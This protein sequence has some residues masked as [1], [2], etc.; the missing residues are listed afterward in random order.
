MATTPSNLIATVESYLSPTLAIQPSTSNDPSAPAFHL[1]PL[2]TQAK[3]RNF[4]P[5]RVKDMRALGHS[6]QI[7]SHIP[8]PASALTCAKLNDALYAANRL[9]A[10]KFVPLALLP[11][12]AGEGK[13]AAREL[14]KCITKYRFVGGVLGLG[15]GSS[16]SGNLDDRS[17][18]ELWALAEKYRVPVALRE[19]WP[20][21]SELSK[22]YQHNLP[23]SVL[24]PLVSHIHAVLN[25]QTALYLLHLYLSSTFD[26][27]P[28]LRLIL[29]HPGVLPS[30]FRRITAFLALIPDADK[31]K[32]PFLDV[33]QHN[34]YLTTADVQDMSSL[35]SLLE[36]I[37]V[38]RVLYASNYPFEERGKELMEELRGSGFLT[39]RSGRGLLGECGGT[40]WIEG[41]DVGKAAGGVPGYLK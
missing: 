34:V 7:I 36:L 30:Q 23:A 19:M 6:K 8:F 24:A 40:V 2:T 22:T 29:C 12:G 25:S 4:G 35:R 27:F 21:E 18:D 41:G 16:R 14:Q 31:P 10:D 28:S 37:P 17:F 26:R 5:I 15:P 33:W 13:D 39:G 11:S 32:R 38:D 20:I 1:L 3:L 9:N